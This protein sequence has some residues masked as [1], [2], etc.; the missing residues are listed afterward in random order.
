MST[1]CRIGIVNPDGTVE[2]IHCQIGGNPQDA[3][4]TLLAHYRDET[5]LRE[6]I[7]LG[8]LTSLGPTLE[9]PE[10]PASGEHPFTWARCRDAGWDWVQCQHV[11]DRDIESMQRFLASPW[12]EYLYVWDQGNW[13][14]ASQE[15]PEWKPLQNS[16]GQE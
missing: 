16:T 7:A 11:T 4:S 1:R 10:D 3:G 15:E 5:R 8:N 6:L 12:N 13:L 9:P 2:H 14:T